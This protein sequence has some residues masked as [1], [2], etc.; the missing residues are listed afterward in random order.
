MALPRLPLQGA[1]DAEAASR[2]KPVVEIARTAKRRVT[3]IE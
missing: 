2:A 3:F 1:A